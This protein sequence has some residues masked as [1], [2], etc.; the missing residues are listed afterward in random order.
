MGRLRDFIGEFTRL[1]ERLP[2]HEDRILADGQALLAQLIACDDWLPEPFAQPNPSRYLQYLLHCDPLER[3]SPSIGDIHRVANALDDA[4][5]ISIHVYG[6]NIGAVRRHVYDLETG[7]R[8]SFVSAYSSDVMPNI[9][10][11]SAEPTGV[12]RTTGG[13]RC[14]CS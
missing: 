8:D 10:S 2:G 3:V 12:V 5:S 13:Q 7:I 6:A 14:P 1:M 4:T 9:W 11:L